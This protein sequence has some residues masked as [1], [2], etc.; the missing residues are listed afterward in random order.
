MTTIKTYDL[1]YH[2]NVYFSITFD[3]QLGD[4]CKKLY[5]LALWRV[6]HL[7]QAI[8]LE[9][10]VNLTSGAYRES[11]ILPARRYTKRF[12]KTE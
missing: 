6:P 9:A 4:K 7:I 3:I 12:C 1:L 2:I 8:Q 10:I 5:I 11:G